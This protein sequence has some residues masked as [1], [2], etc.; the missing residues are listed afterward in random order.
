M[1]R[2]IRNRF[3]GGIRLLWVVCAAILPVPAEVLA[4]D[5]Q[6]ENR[7]HAYLYKNDV[8][9]R[10]LVVFSPYDKIVLS[11]KFLRLPA[12][13]YSFEA[14]WYNAFEEL[15]EKAQFSFFLEETGDYALESWLRIKRAGW[16]RRLTSVSET[17]GFHV[18]FF[19]TW[20]VDIFLNGEKVAERSFKV[21]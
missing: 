4:G 5:L 13:N 9:N 10:P 20:R 17:S 16:M 1:K 3:R 8:F 19:G 11:V 12:G 21:Q 2:T 7:I 18:K 6:D 15:Q 14:E